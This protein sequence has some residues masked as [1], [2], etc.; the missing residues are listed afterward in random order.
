MAVYKLGSECVMFIIEDI[1]KFCDIII[2][3]LENQPFEIIE[4]FLMSY[5]NFEDLAK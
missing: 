3:N 1:I 5:S 2:E 4:V